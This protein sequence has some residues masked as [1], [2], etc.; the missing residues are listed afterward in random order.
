MKIRKARVKKLLY[1][2]ML[3][4]STL[5]GVVFG[6]IVG[7]IL[8]ASSTSKWSARHIM[9]MNFAGEIFLRMLKSLI[10][11]LIMSSLI[12]AIGTLNLKSSGRIGGRAIA[13][14]VITTVMAVILGIILVITIRPGVDRYTSV[15]N[16]TTMDSTKSS[17]LPSPKQQ[18]PINCKLRNTTTVDTVL[19][20]IRNMF[21]PNIVQAYLEQ[22]QTVLTLPNNAANSS[23]LIHWE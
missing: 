18:Q 10:L 7:L 12:S 21:P 20:L 16:D 4:V 19:D 5:A 1:E 23:K 8:R 15:A 22:Y 13:Y 9:Y 11:P 14:Y 2:Q 6:V 17:P 3:T